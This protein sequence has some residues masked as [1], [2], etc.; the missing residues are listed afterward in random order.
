MREERRGLPRVDER[1][2]R[3]GHIAE[4]RVRQADLRRSGC[5]ARWTW[6]SGWGCGPT[7]CRAPPA[8]TTRESNESLADFIKR[9]NLGSF[10]LGP[11]EINPL[12]FAN[13]AAT[14]ASG[15][16]WCPP[17]PIDKVFDRH[18]KEV[19]VTTETCEQV[20]PEGLANTLANAM[21][22]DDQGGGHRRRVGGRGRAGTCRCRARPAPPRRT[23]RRRSSGSPTRWPAANYI[24]D[25]STDA[26][27]SVLVPAA[28]V[29]LG[30]PVRRQRARPDLVHR[31]EADRQ[32]LRSRSRCRRPTRATSTARPA[33]GC[34]AC[35]A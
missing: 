9:Q 31:D 27:R 21:S 10:T 25:D 16:V 24:Y 6:R 18:G 4:H 20:V 12:E 3:T 7:R 33:R 26:R 17:N 15:G 30:Q 1:H 13:V 22:K 34:P 32:Q 23:A 19:A 35:R 2:R 11:F 14:L 29:R 5:S 28:P 8:T